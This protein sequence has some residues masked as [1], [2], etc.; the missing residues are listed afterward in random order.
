MKT[1]TTLL[2]IIA[3]GLCVILAGFLL[4]EQMDQPFATHWNAKGEADGYGSEFMGL[5]FLP[6][7]TIAM[8]ML[9]LFTPAID[10]LKRNVAGFRSEYNVFILSFAAF[11]FYVHA[12]TIA[13]NLGVNFS[14]NAAMAPAFGLFFVLTGR[15]ILKAK[16]NYFIGIRTPWTLANDQ[17]WDSTHQIGGKLFIA[18]GILTAACII[19][20]DATFAVLFF[21]AIGSTIITFVYSYLE[22]RKIEKQTAIE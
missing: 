3:V 4:G 16:R 6:L 9:I 18:S 1:R 12:L 22:F 10:P 21:T 14:M 2:I 20:P 8:S 11:M 7:L 19:C 5:Y 13:W 15:M 17:V